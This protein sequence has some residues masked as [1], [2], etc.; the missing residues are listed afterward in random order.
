M[1]LRSGHQ[2]CNLVRKRQ[3]RL[4]LLGTIQN[5]FQ[6]SQLCLIGLSGIDNQSGSRLL[7]INDSPEDI[8]FSW[9]VNTTPV[10]V[11]GKKPTATLIIDSTKADKAKLTALEAILYGSEQDEPRLPLPDEIATLMASV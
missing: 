1:N 5:S 3:T 6:S 10:N 4:I 11:T 7:T 9:E 2:S 8:T